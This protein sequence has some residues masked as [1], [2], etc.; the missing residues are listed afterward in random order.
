[1]S[2]EV[3]VIASV[4]A[5]LI[6]IVAYIPYIVDMFRGK[7]Q[8]HLYT[9]ISITLI[10]AMIAYLQVI[11][12]AG[13]GAI[14]VVIGVFIDVIILACCFRFGTKDVVPMDRICLA[15]SLIG[16]LSYIVFRNS[17]VISLVIITAAEMI[18]FIPTF[19]KTHNA[20]YSEALPSYYLVMLK[21]VLVLLALEEYN[22]LTVSYPVLWLTLFMIFLACTYYWRSKSKHKTGSSK[23][24]SA[25]PV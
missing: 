20:P 17:P 22:W 13:L 25:L 4:A 5:T 16:I 12:G 1:M 11:G 8:P 19:R 6:A 9:W 7:N 10:T 15:F 2:H 14:P 3:K 18:S 23:P 21:L 24:R